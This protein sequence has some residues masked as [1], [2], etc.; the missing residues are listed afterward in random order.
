MKKII[1]L[2]TFITLNLCNLSAQK[3]FNKVTAED[4]T[5]S[6]AIA[7]STADAVYIYSI[8]ESE[9]QYFAERLTIKTHIKARLKILTEEGREHA[10]CSVTYTYSKD[11]SSFQ[12]DNIS[13]ISA[14][15]YNLVNGKVVKTE[16]SNKYVFH[17]NI[18]DR[19]RKTK[20]SIPDAKVGSI[21]E[22][23]FTIE[24]PNYW[25]LPTW[26]VQ[27]NEPVLYSYYDITI[28]EWFT[29]N[30]ECRGSQTI[31]MQKESVNQRLHVGNNI[32]DVQ[33]NRYIA[34]AENLPSF[35]KENYVICPNDYNTHIDF[36]VSGIQIP[37]EIYKSFTYTWNDVRELLKKNYEY[38]SYLKAKNPYAEEMK[39]LNLDGLSSV[40]KASKLF[41]FIH[42]K[43]K[44]DKTYRLSC[45]SL[46]KVAKEG[47]GSNIALNFIYMSMLRDAGINS[48]PLLIRLRD[49]GRLPITHPSIDKLST[50]VVAF[51]D[52]KNDIYFADCSAEYGDINVLP[53]VLLT[54]GILLD[55]TIAANTP[56]TI[57]LRYLQSNGE[58]NIIQGI[59]SPE[60]KFVGSCKS[61]IFG[62]EALDFKKSYHNAADSVTFIQ[63]AEKHL[64]CN[65]KSIKLRNADGTGNKT[66]AQFL[67]D[68]DI[69]S[70]NDRLYI[71]PM[72]LTDITKSPF[73]KDNRKL[74][75]EFPYAKTTQFVTEFN[76]PENYEIESMPENETYN[77]GEDCIVDF[78]ITLNGTRLKT[79]YTYRN[80]STFIGLQRYKELQ[81][82]YSK[83]VKTNS[84]IIVL[85][86]K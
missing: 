67:F 78:Q 10:D 24:S 84:K 16:M 55:P 9:F 43:L 72:I 82:F 27:L 41:G 8:G 23:E 73:T 15:S 11:K 35:K 81:D 25:Q 86:K 80:N 2:L 60:N 70:V 63:E 76:I 48:T 50:F 47:N 53:T 14:T 6:Y 33:S 74:P 75:V 85:K 44:W 40:Q 77:L 5:Q 57:D 69:R 56:Q 59:I 71:N 3:K 68:K 66:T 45:E 38:N 26:K 36:E 18:S 12:N 32:I 17:E 4:F 64:G 39:A 1:L 7:D 37:G 54:E 52:E 13:R 22:Y 42:S 19:M 28:P 46:N 31:N 62:C 30:V 29:C 61:T 65:I 83:L 49:N 21:I 51:T 34:E 58:S 20:F 79:S